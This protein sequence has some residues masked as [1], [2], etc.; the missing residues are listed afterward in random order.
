MSKVFYGNKIA[1]YNF[2]KFKHLKL[3]SERDSKDKQNP[4][5][6]QSQVLTAL[7]LGFQWF[8]SIFE[9]FLQFQRFPAFSKD[10]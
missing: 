2:D 5:D 7:L 4:K 1:E 9:G 8:S 10:S 6:K 3:K